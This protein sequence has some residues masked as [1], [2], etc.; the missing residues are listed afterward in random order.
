MG[1]LAENLA[2]PYYA[3]ILD[4]TQDGL[5]S[6]E[7]GGPADHMVT[8]ATCQPG[9]LGLETAHDGH[10]R[11]VTVSYW[12]NI[13]AIECWKAAGDNRLHERFGVGLADACDIWI[14]RVDEPGRF[15]G[16]MQDVV[17]AARD[18]EFRGLG[19]FLFAAI[20]SLAGLLP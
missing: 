6:A 4:E 13:A 7:N 2:P 1:S 9:F 3:A 14:T 5:G 8:L 17:L 16:L 18:V 11:R 20:L 19:A 12:E 10:G 15:A